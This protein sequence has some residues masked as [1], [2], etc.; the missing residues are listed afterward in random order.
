MSPKTYYLKKI[1]NFMTLYSLL[2]AI[3]FDTLFIEIG[4]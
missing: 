1:L 4:Q 3:L 2:K